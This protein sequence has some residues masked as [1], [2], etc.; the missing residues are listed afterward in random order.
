MMKHSAWKSQ[1]ANDGLSKYGGRDLMGYGEKPPAPKW[2]HGAKV[3]INFI[4]VRYL[5]FRTGIITSESVQT[6]LQICL[7]FTLKL[8]IEL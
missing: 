3:A 7:Y 4:I 2:P 6:H 8:Y 5:R 1:Q